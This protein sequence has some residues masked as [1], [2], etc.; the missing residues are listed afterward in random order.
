MI[1]EMILANLLKNELIDRPANTK[2]NKIAATQSMFQSLTGQSPTQSISGGPS[3]AGA[4]L[5]G[6][7]AGWQ[8]RQG[9]ERDDFNRELQKI[10]LSSYMGGGSNRPMPR[11]EDLPA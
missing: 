2:K 8:M 6:G 11:D 4:G 3:S 9:E 7:L 10:M 1:G 5:E